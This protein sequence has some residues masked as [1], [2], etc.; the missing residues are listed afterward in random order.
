M[1]SKSFLYYRSLKILLCKRGTINELQWT[2][3]ALKDDLCAIE[4]LRGLQ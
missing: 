4:A 1:L 2:I 3:E